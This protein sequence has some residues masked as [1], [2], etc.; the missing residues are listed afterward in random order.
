LPE[1]AVVINFLVITAPF[2]DHKNFLLS[3]SGKAK[4]GVADKNQSKIR[5]FAH[6]KIE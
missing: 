2:I 1:G 5:I 4:L 3:G 6:K